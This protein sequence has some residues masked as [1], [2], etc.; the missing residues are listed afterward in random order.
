MPHST[1][2][3]LVMTFLGALKAV[4]AT[5]PPQPSAG[6][7]ADGRVTDLSRSHI[8]HLLTLAAVRAAAALV[9]QHGAHRS[10]GPP[11]DPRTARLHAGENRRSARSGACRPAHLCVVHVRCSHIAPPFLLVLHYALYLIDRHVLLVLGDVDALVEVAPLLLVR[12]HYDV[13]PADAVSL[14]ERLDALRP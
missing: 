11:R 12:E 2:W 7:P 14:L 5:T 8:R 6:D 4:W 1:R 13:V 9:P 10:L 3:R